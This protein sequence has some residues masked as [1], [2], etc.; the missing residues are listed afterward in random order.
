M[1]GIHKWVFANNQAWE[2]YWGHCQYIDWAPITIDL[3][4]EQQPLRDCAPTKID[5]GHRK[6]DVIHIMLE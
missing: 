3:G 1:A 5:F 6:I 4:Y 2:N